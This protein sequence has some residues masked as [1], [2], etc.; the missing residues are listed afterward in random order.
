MSGSGLSGGIVSGFGGVFVFGDVS[1]FGDVFVFG[2]VSVIVKDVGVDFDA[3]TCS[4]SVGVGVGV[5]PFL[6]ENFR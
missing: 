6:L 5:V 4:G 2:G 3:G 1:V